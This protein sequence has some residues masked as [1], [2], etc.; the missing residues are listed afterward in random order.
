MIYRAFPGFGVYFLK[1]RY[2]CADK[3]RDSWPCLYVSHVIVSTIR[4]AHMLMFVAEGY[5]V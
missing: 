5:Q 1:L 3:R 2:I 4:Y